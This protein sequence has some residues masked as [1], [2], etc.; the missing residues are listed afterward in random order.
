MGLPFFDASE[1]RGGSPVCRLYKRNGS[2]AAG[3]R[4]GRPYGVLRI[5]GTVRPGGRAL[6]G[7]PPERAGEGTRPYGVIRTGS[8]GSE[9]AGA[10]AGP[11]DLQFST[12]PGPSGPGVK[13][14]HAHGSPRAGS[15][16][17]A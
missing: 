9:H 2:L 14:T 3:D 16:P 15:V 1:G 17:Q 5:R 13:R 11:Q 7:E 8:V 4:K 10:E 12:C 6:Q